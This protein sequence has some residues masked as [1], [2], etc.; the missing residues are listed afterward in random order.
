MIVEPAKKNLVWGEAEQVVDCLA[1][2][3]QTVQLR[4][5]LDVD[6]REQTAADDL[7]DQAEDEMLAALR[8][9]RCADVDDRTS[10]RFRGCDHDVVVFGDLEV[11]EGLGSRRLVQHS[12]VDRF[13]NRVIDEL[14]KNESISAIVEQLHRM[15]RDR[16]PVPDIG[17]AVEHL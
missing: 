14:G 9:V 3:A 2:F 8:K 7:P 13:R 5:E 15:G 4:V 17:V 6:L 12:Y 16:D 10:D 11:V 1:L